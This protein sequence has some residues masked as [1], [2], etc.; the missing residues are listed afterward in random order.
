MKH[1]LYLVHS[2]NTNLPSA[3]S[4]QTKNF[5]ME[6][7]FEMP[8]IASSKILRFSGSEWTNTETPTPSLSMQKCNVVMPISVLKA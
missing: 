8:V 2:G 7:I 5:Q 1:Y 4:D 3:H 6:I